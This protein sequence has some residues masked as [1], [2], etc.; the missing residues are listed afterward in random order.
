MTN[1]KATQMVRVRAAASIR[2]VYEIRPT[3]QARAIDSF[4]F[5]DT[6]TVRYLGNSYVRPVHEF[7][8]FAFVELVGKDGLLEDVDGLGDTR[9]VYI[10]S[11]Q[12]GAD[13]TETARS[14]NNSNT[15]E[16]TQ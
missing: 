13:V 16:S 8:A 12:P 5:R 2:Q 14:S 3:V 11:R 9:V 10:D 6:G 15:K 1:N 4:V 7:E